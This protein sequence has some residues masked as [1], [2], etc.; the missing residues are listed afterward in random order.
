[1]RQRFGTTALTNCDDLTDFDQDGDGQEAFDHGGE[2]CDDTDPAIY[3]G[4]TEIWY[5][6]VDQDCNES[7]DFDQDGDGEES[8]QYGGTDC[9]DT[10]ALINT[11]ASD[12]NLD[13]VDNNCDG[14]IDEGAQAVTSTEMVSMSSTETATTMTQV[15]TQVHWRSGMTVS[16]QTALET[17]ILTKMATV[18]KPVTTVG[19]TVMTPM[20]LSN[21]KCH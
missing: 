2:D 18:K 8:D 13:G 12:A 7:N 3:L 9:D 10:N 11:I 5:D 20:R 21:S 17:T 1:M 16:T 6:G 15:S 14:Q 4:A 19:L